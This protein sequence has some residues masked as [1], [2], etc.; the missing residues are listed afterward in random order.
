MN[1]LSPF[2]SSPK[3]LAH[4]AFFAFATSLLVGCAAPAGASGAPQRASV[5]VLTA[6]QPLTL[7][8]ESLALTASRFKTG[9]PRLKGPMAALIRRA[10]RAL[11]VPLRSVTQKSL[12]PGSGDKRDYMSMGPYWWPN[13]A[14][15]NGL[16]YVRR[17]GVRNPQ[18]SDSAL[19]SDRMVAM[20]SDVRD[21]SLA[22]AFTGDMR[23]ATKC[24]EV[25][26]TWFIDPSLRMNP[27]LRF[28]QSI[29][30]IIDGRGIG[31]IDTREFWQVVDAALLIAPSEALKPD[32]LKALRAWFGEYAHWLTTSEVGLEERAAPNNHGM[33]FDA[34]L[35]VFWRFAGEHAKARRVAF[36][37]MGLRI[38][39]QVDNEGRLPLELARTRPFHYTAFATQA[40]TM[41][42]LHAAA[43][44]ASPPGINGLPDKLASG[45][46][47][48][49]WQIACAMDLWRRTVENRSLSKALVNLATIVRNP[50]AWTRGTEVE[51]KPLLWRA[52][53]PLLLGARAT[54]DPNMLAA[55]TVLRAEPAPATDDV[56]WLLWPLP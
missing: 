48:E 53:T 29:P 37:A 10:D 41:I 44:D 17:D 43:L 6:A 16:P 12:T 20:V 24:A 56:A 33:F 34:Q 35:V 9:D 45:A 38:A 32:E 54:S 31:I 4:T 55:L 5:D 51:P 13:P 49:H 46:R 28:G 30:G 47:C 26:R 21:L 18:A 23:Y 36:D 50:N 27:N 42:A 40:A 7:S 25:L 11:T 15:P 14:T 39:A 1:I 19:D 2:R 8:A 3:K 52:I 22:H